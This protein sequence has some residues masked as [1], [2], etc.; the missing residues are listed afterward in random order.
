MTNTTTCP[1][2]PSLDAFES[3]ARSIGL[4]P[5]SLL[6]LLSGFASVGVLSFLA[7]LPYL[8][9]AC[10]GQDLIFQCLLGKAVLT[11]AYDATGNG[12]HASQKLVVD[13]NHGGKVKMEA[14]GLSDS[15]PTSLEQ[16]GICLESGAQGPG[17][18][19]DRSLPGFVRF[20]RSPAE[21]SPSIAPEP[22]VSAKEEAG[23][24]GVRA[25]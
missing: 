1:V 6:G 22:P 5:T 24:G 11:V 19:E 8:F 23:R 12:V 14:T 18:V 9:R 15:P 10:R 17:V 3:L 2:V 13:M 25:K 20:L 16:P 4:S 7:V 21:S